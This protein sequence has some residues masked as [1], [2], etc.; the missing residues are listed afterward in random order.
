MNF[1][2]CGSKKEL[3]NCCGPILSGSKMPETAEE[4]MRARYS[5][6][7]TGNISF[8]EETH[9]SDT[10]KEFDPE[11][12][13]E[14]SKKANWLGLQIKNVQNGG[15]DDEEGNVEFIATYEMDGEE[16]NHH[17]YSTFKKEN[18]KWYF[19]D[20]HVYGLTIERQGPKVGRNDP[21]P[22]GSGKK[23]KKCCLNA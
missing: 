2:H 5:A 14:W 9:H 8:I 7:V 20:G 3:K 1:C 15:P 19:H 23:Y 17:E 21:C 10:R 12:A 16:K 4:T 18:G 13:K 6:Y 11:G 22:C